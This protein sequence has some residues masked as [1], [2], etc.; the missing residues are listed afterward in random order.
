MESAQGKGSFTNYLPGNN[1]DDLPFNEVN[2]L[3]CSRDGL[4]WIGLLGGGVCT[5]N[6]RKSRSELDTLSELRKFF[7]TSSVRSIFQDNEGCLWLGI[8]GFGLVKYN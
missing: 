7:P 5:V 1:T 8:M 2:A 4:M 6:T 3:L